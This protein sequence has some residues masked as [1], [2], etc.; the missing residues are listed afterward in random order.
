MG[1][2]ALPAAIRVHAPAG[3]ALGPAHRLDAQWSED[4]LDALCTTIVGVADSDGLD[5]LHFHYAL[6]FAKVAVEVRRRLA[7]PRPGLV[8]TLH[9][10]DVSRY[11]ADPGIA[12]VL[13][14]DL[15]GID[16][17]TTVSASHAALAVAN[18]GLATPPVVIPNF[19]DLSRWSARG[20][21]H[22][23]PGRRPRIA[24]VS[25]F[26]AVKHPQ[27]VARVFARV[28][29]HL[30][31]E[32]WLVGDG[33]EMPHVRAILDRRG[34]SSHVRYLGIRGDVEE[35]LP[36][37]DVL[38]MTSR[39]ESFCMAALEAMACGVAVVAPRVGGLPE[40]VDDGVTG[41]LFGPGDE[42]AAADA[43]VG[44]LAD[45]GRAALMASQAARRAMVLSGDAVVPRYESL[46]LDLVGGGALA[47]RVPETTGG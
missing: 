31:A 15:G 35:I 39:S 24:H 36:Q 16:R 20:R 12:P 11:G 25:N 22:L 37:T 38:L 21:D 33:E 19:V 2:H 9:G 3:P 34:L 46:Y 32:L 47:G 42:A 1:A 43:V 8:G 23:G 29:R 26:R 14:R 41:H 13:A 45:P 18:L 44:I 7:D 30:D 28:R 27:G 5:V 40:L 17:L 10:T 4:E 6:P